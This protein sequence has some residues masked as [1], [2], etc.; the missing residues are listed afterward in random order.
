VEEGPP[1]ASRSARRTALLLSTD[2]PIE[3]IHPSHGEAVRDDGRGAL[4]AL[5]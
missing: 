4:A 3:Q 5:L 1:A 2:L